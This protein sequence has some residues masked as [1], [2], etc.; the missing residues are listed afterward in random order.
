[1]GTPEYFKA[2]LISGQLARF[3][4]V[5]YRSS[6]RNASSAPD[7]RAIYA[8][9]FALWGA[10][11]GQADIVMPSAGWL[12]GGL[13]ASPEKLVIDAEILRG[14]NAAFS[15]VT[16][17]DESLGLDAVR[18]VGPGGHSFG[19]AH[20]MARHTGEFYVPLLSDGSNFGAWTAAGARQTLARAHHTVNT[21][22]DSYPA[23]AG[24]SCPDRGDGR[25]RRAPQGSGRAA[26]CLSPAPV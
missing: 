2:A 18:E 24:R 20:T 13:S 26:G 10:K 21:L 9:M 19:A 22:L 11:L 25:L 8:T 14:M 1:M 4:G 12:E 5:P 7:A 15:G 17:D 3:C 16:R 23:A 6:G